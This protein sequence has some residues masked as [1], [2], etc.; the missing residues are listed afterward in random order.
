MKKRV[1][2]KTSITSTEPET[3]EVD[4]RNVK[5]RERITLPDGTKIDRQFRLTSGRARAALKMAAIIVSGIL[6]VVLALRPDLADRVLDQV[7]VLLR[8]LRW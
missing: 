1:R 2:G 8:Q 7:P 6:V 4:G 3:V 5:W